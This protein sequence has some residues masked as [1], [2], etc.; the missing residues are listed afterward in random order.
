MGVTTTSQSEASGP[1]IVEQGIIE[2]VDPSK[3]TAVVQTVFSNKSLVDVKFAMPFVS[4]WSRAGLR[5]LPEPG[6][7]CYVFTPA[8][9]SGH[10]IM[11]FSELGTS[12]E[13]HERAGGTNSAVDYRG[14]YPALDPGDCHIGSLDN[15][16]IILKRGGI[17]QIGATQLAQRMYIPI[18]NLVRDYYQRYHGFSPMGEMVWDHANLYQD[19]VDPEKADVPVIVKM[20][21]RELIRHKKMT[22]EIR[23]G[24]LDKDTLDGALDENLLNEGKDQTVTL[25]TINQDGTVSSSS[26]NLGS[27]SGDQEHLF[28]HGKQHDGLGLDP[29]ADDAPPG[30]VSI[31]IRDTENDVVSYTFQID[32]EGNNFLRAEGHVHVESAKGVFFR[33]SE[34]DGFKAQ[35]TDTKHIELN[36]LIRLK[37]KE[38]LLE[39]LDSGDITLEGANIHLKADT[40]VTIE[41][42][43]ILLKGTTEV[44]IDTPLAKF[45]KNAAL[46]LIVDGDKAVEMLH[47]HQHLTPPGGGAPTT[48][49]VPV[50]STGSLPGIRTSKSTST[51]IL[52]S[53]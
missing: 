39:I 50:M 46:D 49:N 45:G 29:S 4:H 47:T 53:P 41:A 2:S 21:C 48:P 12:N 30:V 20:S 38:A 7:I 11:G 44:T 8:D 14:E 25:D 33:V 35:S 26:V 42:K 37:V 16:Y 13:V 51:K 24:R 10:F 32:R 43:T 3:H 6:T 1:C 27:G 9:D 22:V 52:V 34:E 15:N 5:F 17:L 19:N 28:A 23:M 18:E 31:A 40:N 36:D